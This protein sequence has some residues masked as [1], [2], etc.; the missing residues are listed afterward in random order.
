M[1]SPCQ[2]EVQNPKPVLGARGLMQKARAESLLEKLA[3]LIHAF[4]RDSD[5]I[6]FAQ[7]LIGHRDQYAPAQPDLKEPPPRCATNLNRQAGWRQ[8]WAAPSSVPTRPAG[9]EIRVRFCNRRAHSW[10]GAVR[11][12]CRPGLA[13]SGEELAARKFAIEKGKMI[14]HLA[15]ALLDFFPIALRLGFA[16]VH[17]DLEQRRRQIGVRIILKGAG[18]GAQRRIPGQQR[19]LRDTCLRGT[20]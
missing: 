8:S 2:I 4:D 13:D 12:R 19:R 1:I 15:L 17:Q 11:T 20:R 10:P 5:M 14:V 16:Q 9:W 6:E 7:R 3:G 18:A